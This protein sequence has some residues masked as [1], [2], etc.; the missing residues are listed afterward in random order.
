V[1]LVSL[2][3]SYLESVRQRDT[4][5]RYWLSTPKMMIA[6]TVDGNN[7]VRGEAPIIRKC[8]GQSL[9]SLL[10]WMKKQGPLEMMEI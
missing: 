4:K 5:M 2:W 3:V 8:I 6:V 10:E 1:V 9:D 7:I